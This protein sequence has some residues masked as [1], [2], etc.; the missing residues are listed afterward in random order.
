MKTEAELSIIRGSRPP[1][2]NFVHPLTTSKDKEFLFGPIEE[3][4]LFFTIEPTWNLAHI[5]HA[6]GA[7]TSVGEAKKNG[8]NKPI[9]PGWSEFV[10]TKRRVKVF[11]FNNWSKEL[12]E[13]EDDEDDEDMS[14]WF[15]GTSLWSFMLLDFLCS[16]LYK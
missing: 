9:P 16:E 10:V 11:I 8:W 15:D 14:S 4:E 3:H 13:Y 5:M 6:A 2:A 12:S 1:E 7:F